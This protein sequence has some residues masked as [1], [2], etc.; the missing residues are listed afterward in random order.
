MK[1]ITGIIALV[2]A[3]SL[4]TM[5]Q[6]TESMNR[7]ETCKDNYRT[8]FGSEALTGQG[9]DPEMMDIL[10][11]FIFGEVF[12]TGKLTMKQREMITCITLATMQTLPQLKAH[13]GAAL[14][15]GVTPEELREVM[16]LTA[17]FIGFPKMLNAV[18]TVNEVLKERGIPL[19]LEK[20]GTVTEDT[21]HVTGKAI[22]DKLY[23][24]G[25][26]SVMEGLPDGMGK[27]VERFLTD[28]FFG[29]IYSRGAIDLQTRE[30]LG[31]CVLTTLEAESQ[32][33]SH[34]HGNMN[35]GNTPETLTAAVIQCLPYIG[36][37]A[38]IKALRII[39]QEYAR[40]VSAGNNLVRLSK[41]TVDAAQLDAYNAFLK[42]EIEASMRLEPGVLTLY[43]TAEKDNPNKMTILEIYADRAAYESHLK[44]PHFQKYK[45]GTLS[46]VKEL[47]LVDVKPL[48]PGLKIK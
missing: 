22:Q 37:P 24:G 19:P 10:Q 33:Q 39:K 26:A 9:T 18:A 27:D 43:A 46:M 29:E 48:I 8:L 11:K 47:E 17:P 42:E 23:P 12:Q 1:K 20:Q 13:A 45:Q 32:L 36:F 16:Y 14:N 28:Y 30:L 31:Y 35:V 3:G 38:A 44:T 6:T 40:P 5:A 7:I 2:L 4:S 41:I 21:R 15:V 34:Y 25:I